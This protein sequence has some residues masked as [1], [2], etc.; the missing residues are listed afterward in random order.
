MGAR[1]S[2]AP[3]LLIAL[4]FAS[5]RPRFFSGGQ[6]FASRQ[7]MGLKR[8]VARIANPSLLQPLRCSCRFSLQIQA[9][10]S[11][12]AEKTT[13]LASISA[14]LVIPSEGRRPFAHAERNL[15]FA[16]LVRL[17]WCMFAF[18]SE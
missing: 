13:S 6:P 14:H 5:L 17:C 1:R 12:A 18:P 8:A 15:Q 16:L 4:V 7:G 10:R 11:V 3:L 9:M 2:V